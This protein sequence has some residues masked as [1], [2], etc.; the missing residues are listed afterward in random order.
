MDAYEVS[1]R[2]P[3]NNVDYEEEFDLKIQKVLHEDIRSA[4]LE[5]L[6]KDSALHAES[7]I[8]KPIP[9]PQRQPQF[10]FAFKFPNPYII[11]GVVLVLLIL[12]RR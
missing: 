3:V 5:K 6:M 2:L 1:D 9:P 7:L 4:A 11:A 8:P 10:K 12:L